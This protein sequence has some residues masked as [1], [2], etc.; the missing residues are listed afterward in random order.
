MIKVTIERSIGLAAGDKT[1]PSENPIEPQQ[2]A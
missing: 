2:S 1:G